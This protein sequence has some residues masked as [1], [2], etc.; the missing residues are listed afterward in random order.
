M[1]D[2][3]LKNKSIFISY[4]S[5]KIELVAHLS[6]YL[7][8]NG[9]KTWYAPR[10]IRAGQQWDE[11]INDAIKDCKALVLLFCAQA[12]SSR[13]VKR[14]L[15]LADK[16]KKPVFW[17]RIERVEPNNLSYFLTSTQWLDW[18]DTRDNT[19]EKLV[20]DV[21]SLD[22]ISKEF[23]EP[24][25]TSSNEKVVERGIKNEVWT[26]GLLAFDT[27]RAAAECAARVYFSMAQK[28]PE[29]S[30]I[31]PTGR[32]ASAIFRA[33]RRIVN[34][35]DGCPFGEATVLSDTETFGVWSEHETSRTKHIN[36]KLIEPLREM[37]KAPLK[38]QLHLL[39]GI[40]T[41]SDPLQ[42]MQKLL[43]EFPPCVHAVSISP[44]GEVLAYEVGT[45]TD[46]DE[47]IDDGP[48]IV[49]VG[50]HSKKY[51]DPNQP[52]KSIITIGL[53]VAMSSSV[54]LILVFDIQKT[55][56]L[57][58]MFN[59]PMTAGLPATLLRN[60]PNAYILT[61]KTIA[62]EAGLDDI[63]ISESDP[64]KTA[65]WIVSK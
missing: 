50:E 47:I 46:I 64:K 59:G 26:K 34:E 39:S 9:V 43:R 31:L 23:A 48:R 14:E 5:S 30:V 11:A 37:N 54:L 22:S 24:A 20:E 29:S 18:L 6:K 60:H 58:R 8:K 3:E 49:E 27:D 65:E 44:V 57:K 1:M 42:K 52:S 2:A 63:A 53:G 33:M 41:D 35:F 7:E 61:T 36:E 56:I 55:N 28:N 51:I 19:L 15:S 32:S 17:L 38:S 21:K 45:Y 25:I 16:Y 4:H 13:Q 12:D 62:H 10:D 40:Y